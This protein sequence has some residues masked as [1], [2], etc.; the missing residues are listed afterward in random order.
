MCYSAILF[1]TINCFPINTDTITA[2][3]RREGTSVQELNAAYVR[4]RAQ[5]LYANF[6]HILRG[7][8][9]DPGYTLSGI[10]MSGSGIGIR[11]MIL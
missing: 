11:S 6:T 5:I 10:E 1:L 3:P 9:P 4:P 7:R 8:P 2:G